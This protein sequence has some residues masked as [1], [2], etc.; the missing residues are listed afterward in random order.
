MMI[1]F[2]VIV[3]VMV[4]IM[5]GM[6]KFVKPSS[7]FK[8]LSQQLWFQSYWKTGLLVFAGNLILLFGIS[9]LFMLNIMLNI[10]FLHWLLAILGIVISFWFWIQIGKTWSGAYRSRIWVANIGA[11]FYW[12]LCGILL[13]SLFTLKPQFPGDDTFMV[14]FGYFLGAS[15]SFMAAIMCILTILYC[16]KEVSEV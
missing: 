13:Y 6:V 16:K 1:F 14:A 7:A 5:F 2:F 3:M 9:G 12:L 4:P 8:Y 10:P 15:I 11:L